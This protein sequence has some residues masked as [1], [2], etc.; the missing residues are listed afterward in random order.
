MTN[1]DFIYNRQSIRKF[2]DEPIPKEDV[3]T[4]ID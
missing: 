2:K 1:L 3:T 4:F